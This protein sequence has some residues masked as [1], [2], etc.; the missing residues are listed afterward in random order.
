MAGKQRRH[1]AVGALIMPTWSERFKKSWQMALAIFWIRR[2]VVVRVGDKLYA[3]TD[4][5]VPLSY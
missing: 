1:A 2:A 3:L 5:P 4:G